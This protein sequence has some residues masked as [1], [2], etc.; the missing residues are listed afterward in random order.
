MS[1]PMIIWYILMAIAIVASIMQLMHY[2]HH[3][4]HERR[5]NPVHLLGVSSENDI[6]FVPG[7]KASD[8][9][10]NDLEDL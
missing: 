10:G 3:R 9:Y 8:D 2:L 4:K 6:F 5:H 1:K 7:D